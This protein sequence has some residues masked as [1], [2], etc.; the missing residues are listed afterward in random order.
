MR[1]LTFL[2]LTQL[3][4]GTAAFSQETK[5]SEEFASRLSKI[6]SDSDE[7]K[8][9]IREKYQRELAAVEEKQLA[10]LKALM[11]DAT[12]K[13]DLDSAIVIREKIRK[14]ETTKASVDE[15]LVEKPTEAQSRFVARLLRSKWVPPSGEAGY[16]PVS[17][18]GFVFRGDGYLVPIDMQKDPKS[19]P[20]HRWAAITERQ[21]VVLHVSG[22]ICLF[23]LLPDG[24]LHRDLYG[25]H[26]QL[27]QLDFDTELLPLPK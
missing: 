4:I 12:K 6:E 22:N 9:A 23:T 20:V 24:R 19:K 21:F 13:A 15:L 8:H 18:N 16:R 10:E 26:N 27:N 17:P 25:D 11:E 3:F 7:V 5:L 14:L 2:V 1:V